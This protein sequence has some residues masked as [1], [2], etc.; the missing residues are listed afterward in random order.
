MKFDSNSLLL[1]AITDR[2]WVGRQSLLE[3]IEDALAGGVTMLQLREKQLEEHAFIEE[4]EKV[5]LLCRRYG[6]PLIINDN[7]TVA[8]AVGADGVHVGAEDQDAA[9]IRRQMGPDFI[10]GVTA[11]TVQQAEAAEAAGADYLGVGAVFPSPTKQTAVRITKQQ[12]N[13]ICGSVAIPAVAIGGIRAENME[14]L[15]GARV[16]GMAVVSAIFG[17]HDIRAAAMDLREKIPS[18]LTP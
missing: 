17:A 1:Y 2:S 8:K 16:S 11:K 7:L 9:S 15:R 4:A 6:V 14:Q 10:I 13:E 18:I 12:L 3:Q 5:L